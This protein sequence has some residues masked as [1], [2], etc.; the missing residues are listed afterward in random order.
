[1]IPKAIKTA[2]AIRFK[3]NNQAGIRKALGRN[4]WSIHGSNKQN[5]PHAK[6]PVNKLTG[7]K[8][9]ISIRGLSIPPCNVYQ[10]IQANRA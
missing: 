4:L 5:S 1:M 7:V 3:H 8:I 2:A 6:T 10:K 9:A